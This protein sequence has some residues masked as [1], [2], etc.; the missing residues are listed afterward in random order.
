MAFQ[1][2]QETPYCVPD[3]FPIKPGSP[4]IVTMQAVD[5]PGTPDPSVRP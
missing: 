5:S 4:A 2:Q 1:E 3:V